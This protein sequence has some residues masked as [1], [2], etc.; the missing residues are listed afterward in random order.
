MT[1]TGKPEHWMGT[2]ESV[3]SIGMASAE[4]ASHDHVAPSGA[5]AEAKNRRG[6]QRVDS[7]HARADG[8][9]SE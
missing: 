5:C 1:C 2:W 4:H 8:C 9:P 3:S 7:P 6:G